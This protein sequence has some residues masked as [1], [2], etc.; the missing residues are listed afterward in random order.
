[1]RGSSRD[2]PWSLWGYTRGK[3]ED[4]RGEREETEGSGVE[5]VE[6]AEGSNRWPAGAYLL[7]FN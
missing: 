1:M 7:H 5:Q 3:E 4:R 2:C 6:G